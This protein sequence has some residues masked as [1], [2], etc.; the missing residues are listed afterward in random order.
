M[1]QLLREGIAAVRAGDKETA[2][3]KLREVVA[4]DQYNEK[5]WFWLA[6]VAETAEERRVCLGNVVVINPNNEK[7]K[8]MPDQLQLQHQ[9]AL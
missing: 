7:A 5:G 2:R 1:E 4:L 3:A 8:Q 9:L 6:S